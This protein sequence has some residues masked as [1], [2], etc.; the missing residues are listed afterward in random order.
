MVA[1]VAVST[2]MLGCGEIVE[3]PVAMSETG[4]TEGEPTSSSEGSEATGV[5]SIGQDTEPDVDDAATSG[6]DPGDDG[7]SSTGEPPLQSIPFCLEDQRDVLTIPEDGSWGSAAV[8]VAPPAGVVG[9]QVSLRVAHSRLSDLRVVLRAPDDTVVTLLDAPACGGANIS[10]VFQDDATELG[11]EQC[12]ADVAAITGPVRAI[13]TLE[14]VL[15]SASSS[16][17]WTLEITDTQ[18]GER[19]TLDQVCVVLVAEGG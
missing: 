19:G 8:E 15:G 11:N 9:L 14:A 16:G 3:V 7:A 2:A 17:S 4:Q 5:D 12:L 13:D 1:A 18:P 10:A 6:P